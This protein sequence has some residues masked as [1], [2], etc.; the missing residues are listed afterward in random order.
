[1]AAFLLVSRSRAN[2]K[3]ELRHKERRRGSKVGK[4]NPNVYWGEL[5]QPSV[6]SIQALLP[7]LPPLLVTTCGVLRNGIGSILPG[8]APSSTF[9]GQDDRQFEQV[10]QDSCV[11][12]SS[13]PAEA[14]PAQTWASTAVL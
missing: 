2:A 9:I 3:P 10:V 12:N 6:E 8:V 4:T 11:A 13:I 14:G 5:S 1:M 7:P